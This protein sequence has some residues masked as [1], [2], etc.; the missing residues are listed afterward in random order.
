MGDT[1][2][3]TKLDLLKETIK[4]QVL[5]LLRAGYSRKR[6]EAAIAEALDAVKSKGVSTYDESDSVGC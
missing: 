2:R 5:K 1:M 3:F 4:W 6:V